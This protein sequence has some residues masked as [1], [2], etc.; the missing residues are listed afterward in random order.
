MLV[1]RRSSIRFIFCSF[2]MML[3]NY[4]LR[5]SLLLSCIFVC[6]PPNTSKIPYD[7]VHKRN[8]VSTT[9]VTSSI[10]KII[11]ISTSYW[12]RCRTSLASMIHLPLFN[13]G[14]GD[15]LYVRT[16]ECRHPIILYTSLRLVRP[17]KP[18]H[19]VEFHPDH[20]QPRYFE[21]LSLPFCAQ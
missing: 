5:N 13:L 21:N 14:H 19:S 16:L 10:V 1:L 17:F 8:T 4:T 9:N 3:H 6:I 20:R 2:V 15:G 12:S 7:T 11:Y 18:E